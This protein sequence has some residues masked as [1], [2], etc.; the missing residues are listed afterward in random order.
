MQEELKRS[1]PDPQLYCRSG[2]LNCK[3]RATLA[4]ACM[5]TQA[6]DMHKKALYMDSHASNAAKSTVV[7]AECHIQE[8]VQ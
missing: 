4:V 5:L 3:H 8:A 1:N 2:A 6:T 7:N